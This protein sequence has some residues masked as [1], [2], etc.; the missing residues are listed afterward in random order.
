M[1]RE[2]L[3]ATPSTNNDLI[4]KVDFDAGFPLG[5]GAW[6]SYTPTWSGT[7]G[8]GTLAGAYI[9]IGRIIIARASVTWGT[10]TSH[11]ASTQTFS[12][13]VTAIAG[14]A[15][16]WSGGARILDTSASTNFQRHGFLNATTTIAFASEA[17]VIVTNTVPMTWA[18]G[19]N[20][21]A[22]FIYESA[23]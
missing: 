5:T 1:A 22:K 4:R 20:M 21:S 23:S 18:N 8:N 15:A 17:G 3:G 6:T 12:L 9:K 2:S 7:L 19:D 14:E 10:T 11:G 16:F 13:P